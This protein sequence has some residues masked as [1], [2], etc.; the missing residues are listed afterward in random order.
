MYRKD[1]EEKT[2]KLIKLV[3]AALIYLSLSVHCEEKQR[4]NKKD[5]KTII[6][7]MFL[8]DFDDKWKV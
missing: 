6:A 5:P 7:P 4:K 8:D 3:R 2:F 1:F